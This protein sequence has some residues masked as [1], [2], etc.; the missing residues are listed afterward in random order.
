M[1]SFSVEDDGI[2][3][4]YVKLGNRRIGKQGVFQT[5]VMSGNTATLRTVKQR[6]RLQIPH[7]NLHGA[8]TLIATPGKCTFFGTLDA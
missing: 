3:D 1:M 2:V 8:S 5:A 6:T 4:A 7:A